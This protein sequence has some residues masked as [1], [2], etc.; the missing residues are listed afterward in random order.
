MRTLPATF[1][2]MKPATIVDIAKKLR[3][4]PSTVSR[5]LNDRPDC[6]PK[7]NVAIG[8]LQRIQEAG[9]RIPD[10]VTI[11]AF[12]NEKSSRLVNPPMTTV[13]Q[14]SREMGKKAAKILID[15]I[16]GKTREP[17]TSVMPTRLLVRAST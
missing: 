4:S 14:P 8:A 3:I 12:S 6:S 11:I 2:I 13:D 15:I 10:D 9:L 7:T 16:E 17:I 5:A 1:P